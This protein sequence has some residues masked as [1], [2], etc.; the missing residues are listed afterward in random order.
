MKSYRYYKSDTPMS[1]LDHA[2]F[3]DNRSKVEGYGETLWAVDW[4]YL[5][6]INKFNNILTFI[7]KKNRCWYGPSN[8]NPCDIE[9]SA[10]V[11]DNPI[12]VKWFIKNIAKPFGL[13]GVKTQD[14]AI[15]FDETIIEKVEE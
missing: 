13:F 2:M 15:V 10:G 5:T 6:D 4:A 11:W 3:C 12:A 8:W 9:Q 14:G 7:D 1:Q